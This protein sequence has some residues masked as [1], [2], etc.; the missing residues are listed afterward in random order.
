[1][2]GHDCF[3]PSVWHSILI[4][5]KSSLAS[6]LCTNIT[7]GNRSKWILHSRYVPCEILLNIP[8]NICWKPTFGLRLQTEL[9]PPILAFIFTSRLP[10]VMNLHSSIHLF[11]THWVMTLISKSPTVLMRAAKNSYNKIFMILIRNLYGPFR[12]RLYSLSK[13]NVLDEF[14]Y[15]TI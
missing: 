9:M 12:R 1:M 15:L 3:S 8:C 14:T 13:E 7:S 11:F 4:K 5:Y 2:Q 6:T 10:I